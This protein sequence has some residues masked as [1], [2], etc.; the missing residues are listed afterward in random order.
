MDRSV[1]RPALRRSH[2]TSSPSVPL[3]ADERAPTL[4][5]CMPN[6]NHAAYLKDA[7]DALFAQSCAPFEIIFV[8]D[9]S[10]DDSLE[11]L[12]DYARRQPTRLVLGVLRLATRLEYLL[13]ELRWVRAAGLPART[14]VEERIER[15]RDIRR[16]QHHLAEDGERCEPSS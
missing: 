2:V 9:A 3:P 14:L 11:I 12:N 4:S 6:F 8:D 1:A 5:V 13:T 16:R 7:L 15:R 10:T